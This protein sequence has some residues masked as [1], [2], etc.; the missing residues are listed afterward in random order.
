MVKFADHPEFKPDYTP[1]EMFQQGIMSGSYFRPIYSNVTKKYYKDD[2]KKFKFLKNIPKEKLDNC[3]W[4][5]SINKY[6]VKAST[7]LEFWESKHWIHPSRPRGWIEW[8]CHFYTG[9]RTDDDLRQT[10][11]FLGVLTRFGQRK[12]KTPKIMQLLLHWGIDG[13][14]SHSE[15]IK[16]IKGLKKVKSALN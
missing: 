8:Y 16:K 1:R 15:Y 11:R 14:K 10:S 7:S 2:Y 13:N 12:N 5:N 6:K 3:V 4:D 9:K